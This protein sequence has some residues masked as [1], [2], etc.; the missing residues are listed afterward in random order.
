MRERLI[1]HLSEMVGVM[2]LSMYSRMMKMA[3][4]HGLSNCVAG[5]R[6]LQSLEM[7]ITLKFALLYTRD[8]ENIMEL[9]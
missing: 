2:W 5:S 9:W 6:L 3:I 7:T 4:D 8:D 1:A